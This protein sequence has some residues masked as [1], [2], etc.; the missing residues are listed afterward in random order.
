MS[1]FSFATCCAKL[2][3][4][5]PATPTFKPAP[6]NIWCNNNVVVVFPFEP[7]I[8]TI[9]AS[10]YFEANS[11]SEITCMHLSFNFI[12]M[13]TV[14][15]IPGL[16]TTIS[17]FKILLSVCCFSSNSIALFKRTSIYFLEISPLSE[18]KTSNPFCFPKIAAPTPLSPPPSIAN[19]FTLS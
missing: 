14:S 16:L 19:L 2:S 11:I 9:V 4:I 8:P 7:V 5:F 15:A 10:V 17:A 1:Y 18:T 12:T 6:F 3:P 13:G